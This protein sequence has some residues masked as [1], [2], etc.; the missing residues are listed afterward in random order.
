MRTFYFLLLLLSVRVNTRI[1]IRGARDNNRIAIRG[2]R[3]NIRSSTRGTGDNARIVIRRARY[4]SRSSIRSARDNAKSSLKVLRILIIF[5]APLFTSSESE[6]DVLFSQS[7][8]SKPTFILIYN[9]PWPTNF[10]IPSQLYSISLHR[11]R[12]LIFFGV[13][14]AN[15]KLLGPMV[16][17]FS[18]RANAIFSLTCTSLSY[19]PSVTMPLSTT[20]SLFKNHLLCHLP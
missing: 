5:R 1:A 8:N 12:T 14:F 7:T 20:I 9:K 13:T 4:N 18:F 2:V 17:H 6:S 19:S 15:T 16:L 11:C 3:E 10:F